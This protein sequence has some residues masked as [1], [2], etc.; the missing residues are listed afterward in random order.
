MVYSVSCVFV[1]CLLLDALVCALLY[2]GM[3]CTCWCVLACVGTCWC[4]LCGLV[5]VVHVGVC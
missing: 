1:A 3:C 2:V 5:S 4:G